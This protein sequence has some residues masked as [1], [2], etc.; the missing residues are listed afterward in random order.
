MATY[1]WEKN[2]L[3]EN[4][5][6]VVQ[7]SFMNTYQQLLISNIQTFKVTQDDR[8]AFMCP[9]IPSENS[10]YHEVVPQ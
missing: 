9:E 8:R 1:K 6:T 3:Y 2:D 4:K 7:A 10:E 5:N